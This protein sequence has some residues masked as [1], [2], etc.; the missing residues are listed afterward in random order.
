MV[1]PQQKV[2]N[3]VKGLEA[4]LSS[5][6]RNIWLKEDPTLSSFNLSQ[7]LSSGDAAESEQVAP[8]EL[9][10]GVCWNPLKL[11]WSYLCPLWSTVFTAHGIKC[12]ECVYV[13]VRGG[14]DREVEIWCMSLRLELV[15][16]E[17]WEQLVTPLSAWNVRTQ[18]QGSSHTF[19][20][21]N[22]CHHGHT[23]F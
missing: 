14:F 1:F 15:A 6:L 17:V 22:I 3:P 21:G 4:H 13:C 7:I 8:V 23:L 19:P 12:C 10:R 2:K 16:V 18:N 5:S 11:W 20:V 9:G